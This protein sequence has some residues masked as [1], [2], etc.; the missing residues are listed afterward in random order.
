MTHHAVLDGQ[1]VL[2]VG[3]GTIGAGVAR[4][5]RDAGAQVTVTGS[6]EA[7]AAEHAEEVGGVASA[8]CDI[9]AH[10]ASDQLA[11][12]VGEVHH[13][14]VTAA[15]LTFDGLLDA[16]GADLSAL[17]ATKLWGAFHLARA[18]GRRLGDGGTMTFTSGMLSRHPTAA[19]PLGALNAAIESLGKGLAVELA[20][21]RVNVVSPGALGESGR[22]GHAGTA[23]DVG[24]V[25][26]A[27]MANPWMS[28]SVL[29]VHGAGA[30]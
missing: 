23:D 28:G 14:A 12:T 22:V 6:T 3:G 9:T 18:F 26:V 25:F 30:I 1:H 10:G 24:A 20:P 13:L 11:D 21:I 15:D 27:A 29:D 5:A 8:V 4:A 7:S 2:V 17:V 16:S 19:A